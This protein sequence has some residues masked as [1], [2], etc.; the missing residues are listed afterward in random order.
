MPACLCACPGFCLGIR[1]TSTSYN[2]SYH[3][4]YVALSTCWACKKPPEI[5]F[6][7][8]AAILRCG[9]QAYTAL[10]YHLKVSRG[11]LILITRATFDGRQAFVELAHQWGAR[12]LVTAYSR[13]EVHAL[14]DIVNESQIVDLSG[15]ASL[16]RSIM[17][18]SGA[19]HSATSEV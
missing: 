19:F 8:C 7:D 4:R 5:S 13:E 14:Q 2:R 18:L 17:E 1:G 10:H 9:V 12:V 15:G 11:D 16:T 3:I 6:H